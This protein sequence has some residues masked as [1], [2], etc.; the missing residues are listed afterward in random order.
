MSKRMTTA[1]FIEKA[2]K[3]HE[4]KYDYTEVNYIDSKQKIKIYCK[5]CKKYFMVSP[6]NHLRKRGCPHCKNKRL[7][8]KNRSSQNEFI[9]RAIRIHGDKYDY[10]MINYVN[11]RTPIKIKCNTCGNIF[12]SIPSNHLVGKGCKKCATI[13]TGLK[14]RLSKE[15]FV[16]RAVSLYGKDYN[17]DQV[18]YI[19]SEIK[20][21]IYC[22]KHG[23][24]FYQTPIGHMHARG[25]PS[26]TIISKGEAIIEEYFIKNNINYFRQKC[27]TNCK[28]INLLK[29]DFYLPDYNM[30]I[31][32]QGLQHY[33]PVEHFGGQKAF[34]Y[35]QKCDLIKK[36]YCKKHNIVLLEIKYN[37]NIEEVL[38]KLKII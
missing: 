26:C 29:F 32:Y 35:R 27:F 8:L 12:Y 7:S 2:K 34:E 6:N 9:L 15:E 5:D 37:E 4:D 1:T 14:N 30:C 31:E 21:K 19:N 18:N 28:Y 22:N 11:N 16:K 10:S 25:C 33:S 38:K 20:V 36:E 23:C 13:Q 17:Y 24:Y 3:I